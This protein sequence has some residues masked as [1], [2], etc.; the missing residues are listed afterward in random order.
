MRPTG[1]G[2]C[3]GAP[4][5]AHRKRRS[6]AARGPEKE[7]PPSGCRLMS[8]LRVAIVGAGIVGLAVAYQ[9]TKSAAR[10]RV[11]VIDREP[12]ADG[13]ST[14]NAGGIAVTEVFPAG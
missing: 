1:R 5:G 8:E 14:I 7:S 11:T 6:Y 3:G 12:D 4:E 13:A 9:L 10:T 2:P